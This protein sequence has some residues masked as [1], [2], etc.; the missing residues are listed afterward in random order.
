MILP[1]PFSFVLCDNNV[2]MFKIEKN[3]LYKSTLIKNDYLEA[4]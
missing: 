1:T 2:K 3:N 4:Y